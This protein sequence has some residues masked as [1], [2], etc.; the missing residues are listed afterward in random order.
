[1]FDSLPLEDPSE[2]ERSQLQHQNRN[3]RW[4]LLILALFMLGMAMVDHVLAPA[5][6]S[7]AYISL[8][9]GGVALLAFLALRDSRRRWEGALVVTGVLVVAAWS[10]YSYGSVRSAS[11]FAFQ[12]AVVMSGTYLSLRALLATTAAS[13]V[14]LGGL[15]WAEASGYLPPAGMQPDLRYWLMGSAILLLIGLQ[16]Y[17][18]RRTTDEVYLRRL[19]QMEDRLRLEHERDRSLRRFRRIFQLN[20]T[21]LLVQAAN[22]QAVVEVNPAFE[23]C[24]GCVGAQVEGQRAEAFW[25]DVQQWQ[26]HCRVLFEK[27]HTGWQQAWWRHADGHSVDVLVCSELNEDPGG[28]LILT[29]VVDEN[30][31]QGIPGA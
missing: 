10:V 22:T 6:D 31:A 27:G 8:S 21:A 16:L 26:E 5:G 1:V 9:M 30:S 24:F 11:G 20:P 29:T 2:I 15:T 3:L 18:T 23:R 19:S 14:I 7:R 4:V 13:V 12:G 25:V 28:L 17:Q